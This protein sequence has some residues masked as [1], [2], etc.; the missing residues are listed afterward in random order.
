MPREG[1]RF[2]EEISDREV[3]FCSELGTKMAEAQDGRPHFYR[4]MRISALKA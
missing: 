1:I 3:S 2:V 4:R